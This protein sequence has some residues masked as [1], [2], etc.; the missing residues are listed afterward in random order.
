MG[1]GPWDG[2]VRMQTEVNPRGQVCRGLGQLEGKIGAGK[3]RRSCL[4]GEVS[5]RVAFG[6]TP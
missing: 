5:E 6:G 3:L 2:L 1:F 4:L